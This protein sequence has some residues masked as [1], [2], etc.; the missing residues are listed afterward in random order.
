[1]DTLCGVGLPE[2]IILG[3]LGFVLIGPERSREVALKL[4]RFLRG[5]MTSTWWKEFNQIAQALRDLPTTLV[6]M[7]E[8]EEMQAELKRT[9]N[10]IGQATTIDFKEG[11]LRPAASRQPEGSGNPWGIE[12]TAAEATSTEKTGNP[13]PPTENDNSDD[14]RSS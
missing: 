9:V 8:I 10:D 4:G 12:S 11:G 14:P 5:L 3:L 13:A 6:R 7:A 1:M 2:L